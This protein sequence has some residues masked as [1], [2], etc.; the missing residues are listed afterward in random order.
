MGEGEE[1][2]KREWESH[3]G[4]GR[5]RGGRGGNG[6]KRKK[7]FRELSNYLRSSFPKSNFFF[8]FFFFNSILIAR[9]Q[10]KKLS[11]NK[12][13]VVFKPPPLPIPENFFPFCVSNQLS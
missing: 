13:E 9:R 3:E 5:G 1:G 6:K 4:I 11:T 8:F 10:D 7:E 12:L 2:G